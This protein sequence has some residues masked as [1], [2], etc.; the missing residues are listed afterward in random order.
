MKKLAILLLQVAALALFS[1]IGNL[2]TALLHLPIPGT[3]I[4]ILLV[5]LLLS[6]GVIKLSWL[7]AGA[8]FLIANL[9]LFFIPSA[10]V[11]MKHTEYLQTNAVGILLVVVVGTFVIMAISGTLTER[12]ITKRR[13]ERQL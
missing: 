7:E 11:L 8:D 2:L 1:Y 13:D 6:T 3:L 10:V 9:V 4:A 12:L 5:F